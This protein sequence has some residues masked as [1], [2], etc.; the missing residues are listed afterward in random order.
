LEEFK[1]KKEVPKASLSL[2]TYAT[3]AKLK[4]I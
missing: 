1:F 4:F 2:E 3:F